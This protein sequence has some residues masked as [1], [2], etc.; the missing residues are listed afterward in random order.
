MI[1]LRLEI[2]N[3]LAYR[4]APLI[5]FSGMHLVC[6]SGDNGAGKSSLLD[7]ITWAL[8]GEAR[9]KRD[10]E[11][12]HQG[13]TEM[14][15]SL[16]FKESGN[17]YQVIRARKLGR[18]TARNKIPASS[19]S[20]DL[21][22]E[23]AG[24]WRSLNEVRQGETQQKIIRILNLE[25]E[26]F[27]SSAFIKQGKADEFTVK[28]PA[29]RKKLL[30]EILNLDVWSAYEEAVKAQQSEAER[31]RN[32]IQFELNQAEA[33]ITRLPEYE[34]VLEVTQRTSE[35]AAS[36]MRD[37]EA[38]MADLERQ[39]E[40]SRVMRAQVA[41][42]EDRLKSIQKQL[43]DLGQ[44]KAT[45]QRTLGEYQTALNQREELLRG[46]DLYQEKLKL[47][48]EMNEKLGSLVGLN[49]RKTRAENLVADTRRRLETER[50]VL[51]ERLSG[52]EKQ[53]DSSA[54]SLQLAVVEEEHQK[55][56]E[57]QKVRD[58]ISADYVESRERQAALK[59][60]NEELKRQMKELKARMDA[61]SSIGA[62]C[63]TCGRE[64]AEDDRKR[65]LDNWQDEGRRYG[66]E[67]READELHK[68]LIANRG[69]LEAQISDADRLLIK[70]PGLHREVAALQERLARTGE[71]QA[72]LPDLRVQL[73]RITRVLS[74][75][76]YAEEEQRQ[77]H[78]VMGELAHL[79]YDNIAHRQ[80]KQVIEQLRMYVE[81]KEKL[82]RAEIGIES[83]NRAL[84]ALGSTETNLER[85]RVTEE[86]QVAGQR[87]VLLET[88]RA[89]LRYSAVETALQ[90]AR[91]DHFSAQRKVGE[92]Q[93]R[94]QACLALETTRNQRK[95]D[96]DVLAKRQ[97]LLSELRTAFGKNGVPAMIIESILPELE[98]SANELLAKMSNGR[99]RV[100]FETQR[101]T[102]KGDVSETLEI[103]INDE[104]GERPYELYSGGEAFRINFAIRVA[105]SKLLAN[106]AGARLQTLFTDEG[107]GTQDAAGRERLVEAIQSI[108]DEFELIVVITHID[109]LKDQFPVRIEVTKSATGSVARLA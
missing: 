61:L 81:R 44:R 101:Q 38:E 30:A 74:S 48:D 67:Y 17:T 46:Y 56:A 28:P 2:K 19:G 91:V 109:E 59:T 106:R 9:A 4:D 54:L 86:S 24:S 85:D 64:L 6:L 79:G 32:L 105:L 107:F 90:R 50:D 43:T 92:A 53:A 97:G 96:L 35:D 52:F 3:F 84:E 89:L 108:Q 15:V 23:D 12:I 62:I 41:Q 103:R 7:A 16:T 11:L 65:I 83:E 75:D 20:L 25:Y 72:Q 13:E 33:E 57:L 29:E 42:A 5:D 27:T 98:S 66:S 47:N 70:L 14:R 55:L 99:M 68:Q 77:L 36:R 58:A 87:A 37:A 94:V 34:Q 40:R 51:A 39:R 22:V 18:A 26:T 10:E 69:S 63:P 45:H 8:W 76:K 102:Q 73:E 100:R 93:Q 88:D 1:P 104:L 60:R 80:L 31:S 71:A 21:M 78:D 95:Q 49:E 82:D